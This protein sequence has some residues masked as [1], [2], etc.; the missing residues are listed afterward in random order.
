MALWH[1]LFNLFR[2]T[3]ISQA[4][5]DE[6][7]FHIDE[8]VD[9]LM[10]G[11][12]SQTAARIQAARLF[13]NATL[14]QER[15]RNSDVSQALED[16]FDDVAYAMRSLRRTPAFTVAAI[17]T[18]ALG[19][20]ATTAVYSM[21]RTVWLRPLP[22]R[23][24][25]RVVR[26]WEKNDRLAIP[27]FSVS[28]PTYVSWC[29]RSPSFESLVAV[30]GT[31]ANLT[32]Q[33]DPERVRSLAVTARFFD[34]LGI[35]PRPRP[36]VRR[37]TRMRRATRALPCSASAYGGGGMRAIPMLIGRTIP[38]NGENWTVIGIAPADMGF[39][40]DID[41]W[42]PLTL[43]PS[44]ENRG[45]HHVVVLGRLKPGVSAGQAEAELNRVAAQ[46]E[47]EFPDIDQGLARAA[48]RRPSTGSSIGRPAPRCSFS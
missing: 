10:A 32:G 43:D 6:L 27:K 7:Q 40:S 42:E 17:L 13:G 35:R 46:L 4:I 5:G 23:D 15:T 34:T 19:I 8:R 11:G 33:G 31:N 24:P 30:R 28:V 12:L 39:S 48:S 21:V 47:R 37:G 44:R 26:V 14:Y 3:Q 41:I 36:C 38:L 1:R 45:D 2:R 20:G 22:Y 18:L 25:D 29:E 16:L 9:E